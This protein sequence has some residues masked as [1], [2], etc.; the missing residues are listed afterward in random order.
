MNAFG[1]RNT[2]NPFSAKLD[3]EREEKNTTPGKNV[4]GG[5]RENRAIGLG[6]STDRKI[7]DAGELPPITIKLR[8]V[9]KAPNT[10]GSRQSGRG[11]TY[12]RAIIG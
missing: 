12:T 4:S 11:R 7:Y 8:R 3:K 9:N 2:Y 1:F 10:P 5:N 6:A